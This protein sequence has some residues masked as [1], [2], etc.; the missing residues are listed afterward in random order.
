M[1]VS[2]TVNVYLLAVLLTAEPMVEHGH[3]AIV[4]SFFVQLD[5][6]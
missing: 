5:L 2:V 3:L 4:H 6:I 1:S